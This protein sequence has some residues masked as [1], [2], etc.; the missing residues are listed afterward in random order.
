MGTETDRVIGAQ[1]PAT[2]ED[3][4]PQ[5]AIMQSVKSLFLLKEV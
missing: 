5:G 1:D 2:P 4:Y 3:R